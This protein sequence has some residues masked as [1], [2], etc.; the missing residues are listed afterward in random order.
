[1]RGIRRVDDAVSHLDLRRIRAH[2]VVEH[3]DA[4]DDALPNAQPPAEFT[5]RDARLVRVARLAV[6]GDVPA[7]N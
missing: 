5:Q 6:A 4:A 3:V 1:M 2:F 7:R